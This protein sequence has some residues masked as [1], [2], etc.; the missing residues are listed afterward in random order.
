MP[1]VDVYVKQTRLMHWLGQ[2]RW[3]LFGGKAGLAS[4]YKGGFS[5]EDALPGQS[6]A[7]CVVQRVRFLR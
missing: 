3:V 2:Y 5:S 7:M 6:S 1:I 4:G